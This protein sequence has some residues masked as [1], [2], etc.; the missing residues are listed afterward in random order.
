MHVD[1]L[2]APNA[3][4]LPHVGSATLRDPD[5]DGDARGRQPRGAFRRPALPV[6]GGVT[7]AEPVDQEEHA[8][9]EG[10]GRGEA[11]RDRVER[12][13]LSPRARAGRRGRGRAGAG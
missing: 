9:D 6:A 8:G 5:R 11:D 13:H 1:L 4:L 12:R 2:A 7:P 3:T 10:A